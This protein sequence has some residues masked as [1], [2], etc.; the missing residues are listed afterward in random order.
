MIQFSQ[1]KTT[2]QWDR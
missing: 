1:Q 2:V